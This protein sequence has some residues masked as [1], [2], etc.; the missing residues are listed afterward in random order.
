M[1]EARMHFFSSP[2]AHSVRAAPRKPGG[3]NESK[4]HPP[5]DEYELLEL[6]ESLEPSRDRPIGCDHPFSQFDRVEIDEAT[7]T[8]DP[9]KATSRKLPL[10]FWEGFNTARRKMAGDGTA[11][12][13]KKYLGQNEMSVLYGDSNTGCVRRFSGET[14]S[15]TLYVSAAASNFT[16][17]ICW[18][19]I[20]RFWA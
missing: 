13:V 10:L 4:A 18:R 17:T 11:W 12:L 19:V 7:G 1:A 9:G 16:Y 2:A 3:W 14:L 20:A 6:A 8:T 5:W 15:I